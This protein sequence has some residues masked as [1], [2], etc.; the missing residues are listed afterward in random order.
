MITFSLSYPSDSIGIN[1]GSYTPLIAHIPF[2][3]RKHA[4][5]PPEQYDLLI[6]CFPLSWIV[7]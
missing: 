7:L 4:M 6:Q 3:E 1:S 2:Y 5:V